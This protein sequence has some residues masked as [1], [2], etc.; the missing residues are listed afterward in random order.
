MTMRVLAVILARGGSKGIPRKNVMP[1][2]GVPLIGRT[3]QA[4]KTCP[5]IEDVVVSTD[6]AEIADVARR[7]GAEVIDRPA[8]LADDATSSEAAM[9]HACRAWQERTPKTFDAVLLA[10]NT[11]PFHDPRDMQ[12]VIEAM[13][14]KNLGACITVTE[15]YKYFW[16][17]GPGGWH[18]PYQK[19]A[20]RQK[21][22]PWHEEAGSLY[23]TRYD[24]FLR[25]GNLFVPPVGVVTIPW[26]RAFEIDEP[27]DLAL[28]E[29]LCSVYEPEGLERRLASGG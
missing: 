16:A 26:W 12:A 25:E 18:M 22:R 13:Q 11:S 9:L 4:A 3:V 8:E 5:A 10:Q 6:N 27:E 15:T 20:T 14:A 24:A 17:E 28:A 23:A 7:H 1:V 29:A 19:R 2:D 21:R